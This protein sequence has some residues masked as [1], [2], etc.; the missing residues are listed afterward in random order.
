MRRY[1]RKKLP[2]KA[3]EKLELSLMPTRHESTIVT[4]VT[5]KSDT[6]VSFLHEKELK[7]FPWVLF[8]CLK[9]VMAYPQLQRFVL[10]NQLYQHKHMSISTV[11][12]KDKQVAGNNS[13]AKIVLEDTDDVY[14]ISEKLNKLVH[15]TRSE[16]GNSSDKLIQAFGK[17]P[18]GVFKV[19]KHGLS[20]LDKW[21]WLPN[22]I[23]DDDP[24]HTTA[25][26]ANLGS[27]DGFS[28]NHHLYNWGTASMFITFGRLKE[29]GSLDVTFSVDERISEGMVLF[30]ALTLFKDILEN[31]YE[32]VSKDC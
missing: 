32:H 12:K 1:D 20:L 11:I 24:L 13:F 18:T 8:A 3:Y 16:Q 19:I 30:K 27:I 4:S 2:L 26:I 9:T 21:D 25:V 31:P 22:S 23:I 17:L 5:I 7:I 15:Q 28:V 10:N 29:D 6:L 14:S